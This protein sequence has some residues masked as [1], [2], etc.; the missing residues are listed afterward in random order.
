M[1]K[2]ARLVAD[3]AVEGIRKR[4][5][6][7]QEKKRHAE[8]NVEAGRAFVAAYVDYVHYVEGVHRAAQG[9]SAHHEGGPEAAAKHRAAKELSPEHKH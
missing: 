9:A 6:E 1:D 5:A 3:S 4:F 8:H 7:V 2:A